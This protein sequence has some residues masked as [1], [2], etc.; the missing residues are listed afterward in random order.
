M[1]LL[2]LLPAIA[3]AS[4]FAQR[5]AN[6]PGENVNSRYTI[7][8]IQLS[9]NIEKRITRSLRRDID[10]MIGQHFDPK[11]VEAFAARIRDEL[12]VLVRHRLE[13]G[14]EPEHVRVVYEARERRWD[15][16]EARV[17][18][19]DY[20]SK[21]GVTAGVQFGFDAGNNRFQF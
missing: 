2:F 3:V 19:L 12:N 16:D 17:T 4:L 9:R 1:K 14:V 8:S 15:H 11:S 21:E 5:P 6:E 10:G 18:K 20:H 13:K 7:E